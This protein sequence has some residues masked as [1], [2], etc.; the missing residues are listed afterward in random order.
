MNTEL[1]KL[2]ERVI[3]EG[4]KSFAAAS[5]LLDRRARESAVLLYAWCRY[6]DDMVDGQTL[7]QGRVDREGSASERL[8]DLRRQTAAALES[9]VA[10]DPPFEALRLVVRR[11]GI[12]HAAPRHLLDGFSLDLTNVRCATFQDT[13]LYAYHVAGVVG[14]MMAWTMDVSDESTLD[15][16]CDLGLAL[17][18]TNIAR[19]VLADAEIGRIYLP[20]DWL[21]EADVPIDPERFSDHKQPL[22]AVVGRLL[23]QAEPYYGSAL[24]GIGALRARRAWSIAAARAVYREI[25]VAV[26]RSGAE[27]WDNRA[28]VSKPR[29]LALLTGA[30][31]QTAWLKAGLA[32]VNTGRDGLWRRPSLRPS[33]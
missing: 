1:I 20:V 14:L 23:D 22:V 17:Q 18:L 10:V 8:E 9:S 33:T 26:R 4:S 28:G 7:G 11:H 25:G 3:A 21:D 31:A 29:K 27:A 13:L 16:A 19:D 32:R 5:R 15:R 6:C 2:S 24:V 30:L 12:P